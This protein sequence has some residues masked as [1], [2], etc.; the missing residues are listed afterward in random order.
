MS[1]RTRTMA[2]VMARF[3]QRLLRGGVGHFVD[4]DNDVAGVADQM[5]NDRGA[6]EATA[7]GQ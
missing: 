2:G 4:I 6:D 5:A 3:L 1:A 7:T